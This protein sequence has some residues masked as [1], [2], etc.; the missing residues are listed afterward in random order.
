MFHLC[1]CALVVPLLYSQL[2]IEDIPT[3]EF[4]NALQTPT[5]Q[6]YYIPLASTT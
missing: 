4:M 1:H 6:H 5:N 2:R 3:F